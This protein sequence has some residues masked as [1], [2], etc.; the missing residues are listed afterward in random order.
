M[1]PQEI[2]EYKMRWC[3]GFEVRVHS[4]L[5]WKTKDWCRK[6]LKQHEWKMLSYTN[7]YEHSFYFE[8]EENANKFQEEFKKWI[9]NVK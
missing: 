4:D 6:Y 5:E 9:I 3:P 2:F 8:L 7:V 1:S